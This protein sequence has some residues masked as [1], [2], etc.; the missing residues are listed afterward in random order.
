MNILFIYINHLFNT[1]SRG[2]TAKVI[3]EERLGSFAQ[4]EEKGGC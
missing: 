2:G 1:I 4:W 3:G